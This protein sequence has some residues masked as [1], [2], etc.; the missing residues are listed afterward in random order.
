MCIWYDVVKHIYIY[1]Y[2]FIGNILF[3][4]KVFKFLIIKYSSINLIGR[5]N[6]ENSHFVK[7]QSFLVVWTVFVLFI[8]YRSI[9]PC[10]H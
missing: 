7:S 1:Y 5:V 4:K 9:I 6:D 10:M 8:N 2:I 3:S